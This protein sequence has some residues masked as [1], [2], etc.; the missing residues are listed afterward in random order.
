MPA[1]VTFEGRR[2]ACRACASL[3]LRPL[4]GIVWRITAG[5]TGHH[6]VA[7]LT[8]APIGI[9]AALFY[10]AGIDCGTSCQAQFAATTSVVLNAVA[11]S[12]STFAGWNGDP[13]CTDG[14]VTMN[15]SKPCSAVF[16]A[17]S[18][19][20]SGASGCFI[21]TAAYGSSL[22]PEVQALREFRDRDLLTN[23][24][25]CGRWLGRSSIQDWRWRL[26]C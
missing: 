7:H 24:P 15:A 17:F 22:A 20:G 13:D 21:A 3:H 1:F 2:R 5:P 11:D 25:G 16:N 8:G 18:P 4:P 26:F 10:P 12:S 14:V 23:A 9:V 6:V 19:P